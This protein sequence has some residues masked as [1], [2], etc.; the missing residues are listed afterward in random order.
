MSKSLAAGKIWK[1]SHEGAI[2]VEAIAATKV[3]LMHWLLPVACAVFSLSLFVVVGDSDA[4]AGQRSPYAGFPLYKDVSGNG[5]FATLGEGQLSNR[6]RWGVWASRVGAGRLGYERPCLSLARIT[7]YGLYADGHVCG[8]LVPTEEGSPPPVYVSIGGAY[9]VKPD[10]PIV[11][12]TV[13][14]LSFNPAVRSA[15][16]KYTDGGQLQRRTRLFNVKQQK[17]TK[18]PP[19]RYIALALQDDVCVETVVGYSKLGSELFSADTNL[20]F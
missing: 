15:V 10:G 8:R 5:P 4:N 20:C 19:F 2:L 12:E 13:L 11:G 14:A 1:R 7:R 3:R 6:T 18:L 17:K 9:R 16:L